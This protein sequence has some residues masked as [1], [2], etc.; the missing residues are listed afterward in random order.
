MVYT[1][2][3]VIDRIERLALISFNDEERRKLL[4]EL[5]KI[6]EM[7]NTV[8]MVEELDQ[9]E[10]LYH[11]HDISLSLRDDNEVEEVDDER[12]MLRDNAILV[13]GYVK[14]PKTVT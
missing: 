9:W 2:N 10:P 6:I 4:K 7:F 8:N 11:V 5:E 1:S 3:D 14:A 13:N 12:T